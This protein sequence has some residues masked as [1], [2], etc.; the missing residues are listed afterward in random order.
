MEKTFCLIRFALLASHFFSF[1]AEMHPDSD[2]VVNISS[3]ILDKDSR[4][5]FV[6]LFKNQ[7]RVRQEAVGSDYGLRLLTVPGL[8]WG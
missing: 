4:Q 3:N 6:I 5:T 7:S 2:N 1:I 8:K